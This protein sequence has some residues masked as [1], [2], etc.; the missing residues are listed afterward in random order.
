MSST[1]VAFW[2][3]G[4]NRSLAIAALLV[5]REGTET[6]NWGQNWS[7]CIWKIFLDNKIAYNPNVEG[8]VIYLDYIRH[9]QTKI[10][11]PYVKDILKRCQ[12]SVILLNAK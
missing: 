5:Q 2:K 10:A 9:T 7:E 3:N 12:G 11:C 4:H 8:K 1:N 6:H